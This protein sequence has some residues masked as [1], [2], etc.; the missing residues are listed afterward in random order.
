MGLPWDDPNADPAQDLADAAG[1]PCF[2]REPQ[3]REVFDEIR[4]RDVLLQELVAATE[5]LVIP[6][7]GDWA[8][9][10]GLVETAFY[11]AFPNIPSLN[12][13]HLETWV[14]E[15]AILQLVVT[16]RV[17]PDREPVAVSFVVGR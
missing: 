1:V 11:H 7:A 6:P 3:S 9:L 2:G 14:D 15:D 10:G 17:P 4:A 13:G 8:W 12:E 5:H 16:W